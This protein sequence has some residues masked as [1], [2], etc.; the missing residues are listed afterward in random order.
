M[1]EARA[2][3][4]AARDARRGALARRAFALSFGAAAWPLAA[5][6]QQAERMP[7]IG[8]LMPY[9]ENDPE[10]SPRVTALYARLNNR[11]RCRY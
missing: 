4:W 2:T 1:N 8:V 9:A 3:A 10:T 11:V 5:G 6:A 7:R